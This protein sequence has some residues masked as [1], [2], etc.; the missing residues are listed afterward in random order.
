MYHHIIYTL[1]SA[2]YYYYYYY[3][4]PCEFLTPFLNV[5]FHWSLNVSKSPQVS[6]TFLSILADFKCCGLDNLIIPLFS[7]L[8]IL[9]TV[10]FH[11]SKGS[12]YDWY[13]TFMCR[14]FL[15]SL[16]KVQVFVEFFYFLLFSLWKFFFLLIYTK[17]NLLVGIK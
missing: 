14:H 10:L 1:Y 16:V 7:N 6:R 15:S 2:V 9:F 3:Y 5:V 4:T 8:L 17:S 12:K 13:V 11:C